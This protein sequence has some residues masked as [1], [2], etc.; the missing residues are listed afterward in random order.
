[1]QLCFLSP[2]YPS[3]FLPP[4]FLFLLSAGARLRDEAAAHPRGG[5]GG[6]V[7]ASPAAGGERTPRARVRERGRDRA[8]ARATKGKYMNKQDVRSLGCF[9]VGFFG[10]EVA[11]RLTGWVVHL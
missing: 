5:S 9:S 4:T 11:E 10:G 1:M 8:G 6:G 7:N 3:C 2:E